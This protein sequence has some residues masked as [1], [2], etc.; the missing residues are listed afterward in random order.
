MDLRS[1]K[2]DAYERRLHGFEYRQHPSVTI[3][4]WEMRIKIAFREAIEPSQTVDQKAG[5]GKVHVF[6]VSIEALECNVSAV[7]L[8]FRLNRSLSFVESF[9]SRV[10]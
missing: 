3:V 8:C 4:A 1:R 2:F 9:A 7:W 5:D 6:L 10:L